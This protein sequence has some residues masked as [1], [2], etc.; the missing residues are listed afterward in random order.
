MMSEVTERPEELGAVTAGTRGQGE[1]RDLQDQGRSLVPWSYRYSER[2]QRKCACLLSEAL[3]KSCKHFAC[4]VLLATCSV[5]QMPAT[6]PP[7]WVASSSRCGVVWSSSS[8]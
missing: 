7:A 2:A 3:V 4:P 6:T 8:M 5:F 1:L